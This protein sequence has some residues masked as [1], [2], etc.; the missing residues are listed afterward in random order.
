M[1]YMNLYE[2]VGHLNALLFDASLATPPHAWLSDQKYYAKVNLVCISPSRFNCAK[3]D[4][5]ISFCRS[6][7]KVIFLI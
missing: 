5:K 7:V 6:A 3:H 1:F 4:R 2:G